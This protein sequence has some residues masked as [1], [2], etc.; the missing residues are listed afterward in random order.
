MISISS[1]TF[2][3]DVFVQWSWVPNRAE[4]SVVELIWFGYIPLTLSALH[5][6]V[7]Y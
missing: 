3:I 5:D 1:L 4:P 2:L 6:N 7:M